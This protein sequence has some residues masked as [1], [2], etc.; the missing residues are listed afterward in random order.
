[1]QWYT[2]YFPIRKYTPNARLPKLDQDALSLTRAIQIKTQALQEIEASIK[3]KLF[4]L[5]M[6][7]TI[8]QEHLD[9]LRHTTN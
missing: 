2:N 1:M 7:D 5:N 4:L 6:E 9:Q 3:A 8:S